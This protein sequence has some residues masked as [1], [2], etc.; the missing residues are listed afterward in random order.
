MTYGWG[1]TS[2]PI[3]LEYPPPDCNAVNTKAHTAT[4]V[5]LFDRESYV[6]PKITF[7][8]P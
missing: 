2:E 8:A 3:H 5:A 7:T 4:G 1:V 6:G